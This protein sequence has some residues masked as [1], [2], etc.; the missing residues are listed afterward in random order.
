MEQVQAKTWIET[1][2]TCHVRRLT[3]IYETV[4]P[5][6]L[7]VEEPGD[8]HLRIAS[9]DDVKGGRENFLARTLTCIRTCQYIL[10]SYWPHGEIDRMSGSRTAA[11]VRH[12]S[13]LRVVIDSNFVCM[14]SKTRAWQR[15]KRNASPNVGESYVANVT[16]FLSKA[17]VSDS[18][19]TLR[20]R[21]CYTT[22]C[23]R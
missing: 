21:K 6:V 8:T 19:I 16:T 1:I 5:L 23:I 18:Q 4:E 7:V 11:C 12:E 17:L 3:K 20:V 10:M 9:N 13:R 14:L 2:R 15:L 22:T